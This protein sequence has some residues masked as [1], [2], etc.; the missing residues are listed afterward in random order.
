MEIENPFYRLVIFCILVLVLIIIILMGSVRVSPLMSLVTIISGLLVFFLFSKLIPPYDK[1]PIAYDR[2]KNCNIS[3]AR[4][5]ITKLFNLAERDIHIVTGWLDYQVFENGEVLEALER[6]MKRRV[7]IQIIFDE[8]SIDPKSV[9]IK[10][11]VEEG[12]INLFKLPERL[13]RHFLVVDSI[14]TR[15]EEP[16]KHGQKERNADCRYY[17]SY[18]GL[19]TEKKFNH[20]KAHT[21]QQIVADNVG[22]NNE[23]GIN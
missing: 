6:A 7:D 9:T 4:E 21:V 16:H 2:A 11:W 8:N 20:F 18:I 14:H 23:P 15:L 3:R 1:F 13:G 19:K 5:Q 12:K 22:E 17:C 10:K